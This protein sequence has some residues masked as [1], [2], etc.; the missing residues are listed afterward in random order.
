MLDDTAASVTL[1]LQTRACR[2]HV[3][4]VNLLWFMM[5]IATVNLDSRWQMPI[6]LQRVGVTMG[7]YTHSLG[8]TH[9]HLWP[10]GGHFAGLWPSCTCTSLHKEEGSACCSFFNPLLPPSHFQWAHCSRWMCK[11]WLERANVQCFTSSL[12]QV[13]YISALVGKLSILTW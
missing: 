2:S 13:T 3:L 4:S 12:K 8:Q 1:C 10:T 6:A 11:K 7:L 5:P 9:A